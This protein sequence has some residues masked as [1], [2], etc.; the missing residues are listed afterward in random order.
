[1]SRKPKTR[2]TIACGG[3]ERE[4]FSVRQLS[5]GDLQ[6]ILNHPNELGGIV[7][8]SKALIQHKISIHRSM[9]SVNGV[10]TI[11]RTA[12]FTDGTTQD[13]V[14]IWKVGTAGIAAHV[15]TH[16]CAAMSTT[17]HVTTIRSIDRV[18]KI[19]K[20][21]SDS[22][23]LAY[24]LLAGNPGFFDNTIIQ[25]TPFTKTIIPF[26]YFDLVV[27]HTFINAPSLPRGFLMFTTSKSNI[28]SDSEHSAPGGELSSFPVNRITEFLLATE[29]ALRDGLLHQIASLFSSGSEAVTGD[30]WLEYEE[31]AGMFSTKPLLD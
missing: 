14:A 13:S 29:I 30:E 9:S 1:M 24:I 8:P 6:V 22:A 17:S 3:V 19:G 28:S 16:R 4:L 12:F 27:L 31:L 11:K 26:H 10:R 5:N 21:N 23:N 2:I 25:N 20:Y 18:I 15:M 7:G